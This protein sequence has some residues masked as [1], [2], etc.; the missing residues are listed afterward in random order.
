MNDG[1]IL[2]L[3]ILAPLLAGAGCW[4]LRAAAARAVLVPAAGV[5][6]LLG[7]VLLLARGDGSLA[8]PAGIEAGLRPLAAG[9][10]FALLAGFL[11][12]AW[13]RKS[14]WTALFVLPQIPLL[15]WLETAG[16]EPYGPLFWAD[17][18]TMA[19]VCVV[20]AV[21]S[22]ICLWALPYMRRHEEH[23]QLARSRQPG[24]FLVLVG[25][26]GVMNLLALAAD[27][28]LFYLAFEATTLCS[29]LLIGHN[30]D[31]TARKNAVTALWMNSVGGLALLLAAVWAARTAGTLCIPMLAAPGVL[32]LVPLALICI[33]G[34]AKAAQPPFM[35]W[36]LGAMVAPTPTSALLHSSTMVKAGVFLV[37]RFAPAFAG[38]PVA[39]IL[40]LAGGLTFCAAAALALGQSDGKRI[41]AYSTISN[42]GLM[43]CCAG[44]DAPWALPA[45]ALL[46][47]F[48]AAA[49]GLLF[50][51]MGTIEQRLAT[52]QLGAQESLAQ[53]LPRTAPLMVLGMLA[54][55]L[56]PFG[57]LLGKWLTVEAA[58]GSTALLLLLALGSALTVAYWTR[59]AGTLLGAEPRTPRRAAAAAADVADSADEDGAAPASGLD[60]DARRTALDEFWPAPEPQSRLRLGPELALA[61]ATLMLAPLA[62]WLYALL[63][64]PGAPA[65]AGWAWLAP[66]CTLAAVAGL[67]GAWRALRRDVLAPDPGLYLAGL[68]PACALDLHAAGED[69][70]PVAGPRA[71]YFLRP[72]NQAVTL[73]AGLYGLQSRLA[74]ARLEPWAEALGAAALL[75]LLLG[76]LL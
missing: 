64:G 54:M 27:L 6:C 19:L 8:A 12:V 11:W 73:D 48:H 2:T 61:A 53:Q 30:G 39:R 28:S 14:L 43:L 40:A 63:A 74:E 72:L 70:A 3:L 69:S 51:C 31:E 18:L 32:G 15:A 57:M 47:V 23:L 66:V 46:M 33:A 35:R 1:L 22:L 20:C 45:A 60:P 58:T 76:G 50:L 68:T 38:S 71:G 37:L 67:W 34:M 29:F 62:P 44:L 65:P 56:P 24:F 17:S 26:L 25:F 9:L 55:V 13:R 52:R 36:L 59:W 21:G 10:D 5:A 42:L 41:L 4:V 16:P 7:A 75:G 49:K